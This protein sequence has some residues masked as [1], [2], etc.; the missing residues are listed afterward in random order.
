M[1]SCMRPD[2]SKQILT[3]KVALQKIYEIAGSRQ[4]SSAVLAEQGDAIYASHDGVCHPSCP[5]RQQLVQLEQTARTACMAVSVVISPLTD[6]ISKGVPPSESQEQ[7]ESAGPRK[8]RSSFCL[9]SGCFLVT[10]AAV[11]VMA[12]SI[13][14]SPMLPVL[15]GRSLVPQAAPATRLC[16]RSKLAV[17]FLD[18]ASARSRR[19]AVRMS[20]VCSAKGA[21]KQ[22]IAASS[23]KVGLSR[24]CTLLLFQT[25]GFL[26]W[27]KTGFAVR[28]ESVTVKNLIILVN[29][30]THAIYGHLLDSSMLCLPQCPACTVSLANAPRLHQQI[31]CWYLTSSKVYS[32]Q[33]KSFVSPQVEEVAAATAVVYQGL[34][35]FW[36]VYLLPIYS[37]FRGFLFFARNISQLLLLRMPSLTI[38]SMVMRGT[39]TWQS[40]KL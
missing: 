29:H 24:K 3:G 34:P 19:S 10:S 5:A 37:R 8:R 6:C 11:L 28:Q 26:H 2:R 30:C 27:C 20:P 7:L 39:T 36:Q 13:A 40:G 12:L 14:R 22:A 35:Y 1:G 25:C 38:V 18:R 23:S 15:A 17:L 32:L 21:S 33:S 9:P 16:S 31:R 4:M